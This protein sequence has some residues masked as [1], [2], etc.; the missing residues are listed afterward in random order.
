MLRSKTARDFSFGILQLSLLVT[1]CLQNS[2]RTP[3][4]IA[5]ASLSLVD[6]FAFCLLSYTEHGRSL[7][8]SSVL[9]VYLFFSLLFDIVR[10]R[11]LWL[12][13]N[14]NVIARLFT[15]SVVLKAGILILEAKEKR[16]YL[17][18]DD[19]LKGPEE[20]SGIFSQGLF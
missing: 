17:S 20:L 15:T 4:A 9:G 1:G 5:A 2:S 14:D 6:A 7:R 13:G 8:P 3:A 12:I 19:K 11:T 18:G 10:V 16:E